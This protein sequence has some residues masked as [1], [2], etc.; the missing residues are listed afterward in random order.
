MS[1][2][3]CTIIAVMIISFSIVA[4]VDMIAGGYG[5]VA[6]VVSAVFGRLIYAGFRGK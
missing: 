6:L 1:I 4:I 2:V 5:V 3:V